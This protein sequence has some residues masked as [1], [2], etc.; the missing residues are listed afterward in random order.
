MVKSVFVSQHL[1]PVPDLGGRQRLYYII[2]A[3]YHIYLATE[4]SIFVKK[5]TLGNP[6]STGIRPSHIWSY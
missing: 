1:L 2:G 5:S 4:K 6:R 3:A